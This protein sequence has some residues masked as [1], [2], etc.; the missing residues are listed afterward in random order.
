MKKQTFKPEDLVVD[1]LDYMF[2]EWLTRR[3]LYS[4]FFA[5]IR[6]FNPTDV[7]PRV[8]IRDHIRISLS[9]S[10]RMLGC[11]VS[12]YF[13]FRST[14]EGFLFWSKVSDEWRKYLIYFFKSI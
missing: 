13:P 9:T 4:K 7:K 2:V 6:Y 11:L 14:P 8:L 12:G 5:N 3:S 10:H 1:V